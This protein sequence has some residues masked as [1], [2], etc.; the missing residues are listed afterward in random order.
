MLIYDII[1][2]IL[3]AGYVKLLTLNIL[4]DKR[5]YIISFGEDLVMS[6]GLINKFAI[7]ESKH[8]EL[9]S[10]VLRAIQNGE[11]FR[12]LGID[13]DNTLIDDNKIMIE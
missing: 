2:K 7:N 6:T 10:K 1:R 4:C 8:K 12:I 9:S 5:I 13:I 11:N 3:R